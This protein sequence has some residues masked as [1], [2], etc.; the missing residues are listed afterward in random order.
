MSPSVEET[1]SHTCLEGRHYAC[2][3]KGCFCP[4]HARPGTRER[5]QFEDE[6]KALMQAQ[7]AAQAERVNQWIRS[8][9]VRSVI[10][11]LGGVFVVI[12]MCVV[13]FMP[14][15][16]TP[17]PIVYGNPAK[18][19]VDRKNEK[20][21]AQLEEKE[22]NASMEFCRF[23]DRLRDPDSFKVASAF[24]MLDGAF[25]VKYRA[26]NGFGG[27]EIGSAVYVDDKVLS[28][29]DAGFRRSWNKECTGRELAIREVTDDF[30]AS[31]CWMLQN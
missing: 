28:D 17:A 3:Y 8:H 18:E 25:C 9:P 12:M 29:G 19:A 7:R 15:S 26:K 20:Y 5:K 24:Q 30:N 27:T 23:R 11:I 2:G 16:H 13:V 14:S 21:Q 22:T 31:P 10:I 6:K 4:C 1:P